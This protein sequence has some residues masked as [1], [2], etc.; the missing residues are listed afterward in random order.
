MLPCFIVS[1]MALQFPIQ[2]LLEAGFGEEPLVRN[3]LNA[4]ECRVLQD[5]K[6]RARIEI[7]EGAFLFGTCRGPFPCREERERGC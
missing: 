7:K 4:V 2:E 5:L 6:H 1:F 3:V